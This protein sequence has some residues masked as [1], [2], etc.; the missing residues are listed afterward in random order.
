MQAPAWPW[1]FRSQP[2]GDQPPRR[3]PAQLSD[4]I[5]TRVS[6]DGKVLA[7]CNTR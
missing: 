2:G 3:R 1:F 7:A 5:F 4:T 6:A